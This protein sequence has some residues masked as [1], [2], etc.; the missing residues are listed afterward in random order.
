MPQSCREKLRAQDRRLT[1]RLHRLALHRLVLHRLALGRYALVCVFVSLLLPF[2][3][4]SSPRAIFL[5]PP[6]DLDFRKD[7]GPLF[8]GRVGIVPFADDRSLPFHAQSGADDKAHFRRSAVVALQESLLHTFQAN[9]ACDETVILHGE[10][11]MFEPHPERLKQLSE[12][13]P[14]VDFVLSASVQH[15]NISSQHLGT[16]NVQV[17]NVVYNDLAYYGHRCRIRVQMEIYSLRY[18]QLVWGDIVEGLGLD[19]EYKNAADAIV[20]TAYTRFCQAFH[21][22]LMNSATVC[23]EK[24]GELD[25]DLP[26]QNDLIQSSVQVA[27]ARQVALSQDLAYVHKEGQLYLQ[28]V[29]QKRWQ[30]QVDKIRFNQGLAAVLNATLLTLG[31][32]KGLNPAEIPQIDLRQFDAQLRRLGANTGSTLISIDVNTLVDQLVNHRP[33]VPTPSQGK[34]DFGG[35]QFQIHDSQRYLYLSQVPEVTTSRLMWAGEQIYD[36][37]LK[38]YGHRNNLAAKLADPANKPIVVIHKSRA[39]YQRWCDQNQLGGMRRAGAF[40]TFN[41]ERLRPVFQQAGLGQYKA[42]ICMYWHGNLDT[43]GD[44]VPAIYAMWKTFPHEL[45]HHVHFLMLDGRVPGFQSDGF[46]TFHE[47]P[48]DFAGQIRFGQYANPSNDRWLRKFK[49]DGVLPLEEICGL[50]YNNISKGGTGTQGYNSVWLYYQYLRRNLPQKLLE[51]EQR[52]SKMEYTKDFDRDT[53]NLFQ[54]VFG[55]HTDQALAAF[56]DQAEAW[57]RTQNIT[58]EQ[59]RRAQK[60]YEAV[61]RM[62]PT[63]YNY[64]LRPLKHQPL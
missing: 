24:D 58:E 38:E 9:E 6:Q 39:A 5:A 30:A 41:N 25:F 1:I 7:G 29:A 18:N 4:C 56:G 40:W 36:A 32:Q 3:G 51:Y 35:S 12:R 53:R 54:E 28:N 27:G 61:S 52:L 14:D 8:T 31:A 22:S 48:I 19:L 47:Y 64:R 55:L 37:Y 62:A 13:Y 42:F 43:T 23:R 16:S 46:T 20:N 33:V 2:V 26:D 60:A 17:G 10:Q 11:P 21:A 15:L 45:G 57:T 49:R 34:I 63:S 50:D 44:P 59:L